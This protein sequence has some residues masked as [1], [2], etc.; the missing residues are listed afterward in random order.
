MTTLTNNLSTQGLTKEQF[1][2]L[3]LSGASG[4]SSS[5]INNILEHFVPGVLGTNDGKYGLPE[6]LIREIQ[7][8]AFFP[9]GL[10]RA[11]TAV[12]RP[13]P[14][15]FADLPAALSEW[16]ECLPDGLSGKKFCS[17]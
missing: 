4:L 16:P 7:D 2:Q 17:E 13:V 11:G 14:I 15:C 10:L 12:L 3:A 6:E 5:T 1:T 9:D 8:E